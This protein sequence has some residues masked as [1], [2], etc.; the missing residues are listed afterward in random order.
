MAGEDGT[1]GVTMTKNP[2]PEHREHFT[3]DELAFLRY[4]RYGE[5]PER[6]LPA[7]LVE[8]VETEPPEGL[9]ETIDDPRL[10]GEAGRL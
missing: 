10:W 8:L 4:A 2:E 6:V 9:P 7:D 1:R 3:D 5:L